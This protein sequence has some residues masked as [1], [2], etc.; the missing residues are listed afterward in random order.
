MTMTLQAVE[1]A[2]MTV[3]EVARYLRISRAKAYE[4]T[5]SRE[6]PVVRM[7]RSVRVHRAALEEWLTDRQTR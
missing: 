2:L 1:P 4:M 6:L 5:Q 3:E 7:G